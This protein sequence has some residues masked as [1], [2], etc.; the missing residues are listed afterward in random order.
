MALDEDEGDDGA[1]GQPRRGVAFPA[2]MGA[3]VGALTGLTGSVLVY[4]QSEAGQH[5]VAEARQADIRRTA[6]AELAASS[7][8]LVTQANLTVGTSLSSERSAEDKRHQFVDKF[9][10]AVNRYSQAETVALMVATEGGRRRLEQQLDPHGVRLEKI[11]A[12]AYSGSTTDPAK[13]QREMIAESMKF[14]AA[15]TD[16]LDKAAA[17]VI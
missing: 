5:A 13:L 1:G 8:D 14:Q 12:G 17:E 10:P 2:L 6:Y 9:T 4:L 3:L 15:L 7:G 11:V 16:F